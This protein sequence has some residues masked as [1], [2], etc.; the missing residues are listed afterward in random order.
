MLRNWKSSRGLAIL[1]LIGVTAVWGWTF[2]GV[3]DAV[4]KMPVMDFLAVRFSVA[5]V[6]LLFIN[7]RKLFRIR[8]STLWQGLIIG[9]LLG[10]SYITQTFGLRT[11]SPSVSGFITGMGVVFTPVFLWAIFRKNINRNIWIAVGL[12]A[13]GLALLS[14]HGWA[15]GA[16]E[17][18][19]LACAVFV[20][21]YVIAL[22]EWSARND[23]YQLTVIQIFTVAVMCLAFAAPGGIVM[24]PDGSV[25]V[26]V[27]ITAVLASDIAF[28][29][30]TWAQTLL[31]PS[32]TAVVM[33]ME[34]VF[35]GLFSITLG[36]E[37]PTVRLI[38]GAICVLVAMLIA[39]LKTGGDTK[40][41]LSNQEHR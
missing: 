35:A 25:W 33:T 10:M 5:G 3:K 8:W 38:L 16:G 21:L 34:P 36:G 29:V 15:F 19:T 41:T 13:G 17:L 2:I 9:F 32:L 20:A 30:Q 24:P 31:S 14:L 27:G 12:T 4:A 11:V 7:P 18:L 23:T 22:G 6:I 37:R 26:T 40:S 1:A 28:L 39:Q